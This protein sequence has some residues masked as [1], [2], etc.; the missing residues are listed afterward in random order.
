MQPGLRGRQVCAGH[1]QQ[2]V[3]SGRRRAAA[4]PVPHPPPLPESGVRPDQPVD[5]RLLLDVPAPHD[6]RRGLH[7]G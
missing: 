1:E 4:D 3:R 7:S 2:S 6:S 5:R